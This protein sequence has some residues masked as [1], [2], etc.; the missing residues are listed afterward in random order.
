[1]HVGGEVRIP[2]PRR[3]RRHDGRRRRGLRAGVA[4][5][6]GLAAA[7]LLVLGG[8]WGWVH[9]STADERFAAA[10]VPE[11]A[12]AVVFGAAVRA[13]HTPSPYL[14][15]RLDLARELWAAGKVRVILVSGDNRA[16]NYDEPTAM[17]DY[18]IRAGVP[19]ELVVRD[20]AG[21][22]SYATCVRARDVFGVTGA[23]LVSQDYHLP[24]AVRI[25]RSVGIDAVGV[26]SRTGAGTSTWT[27]GARREVLADVK[28]V[29]DVVTR[30]APEFDGP[31]DSSVTT[32]LAKADAR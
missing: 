15:A 10:E 1:M 8:S 30:P 12:V 25:C 17:R 28:A 9:A 32:A 18:L 21:F 16:R 3:A 23:V 22:D 27:A 13:D 29:W 24:R 14:A 4:V 26:G 19:G 6:L 31:P 20:F 2:P 5:L 7:P 11:R